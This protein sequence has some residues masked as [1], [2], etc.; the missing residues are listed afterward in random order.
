M[1]LI[2]N[3]CLVVAAAAGAVALYGVITIVLPAYLIVCHH[4]R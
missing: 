4:W 1:T 2:D 3:A